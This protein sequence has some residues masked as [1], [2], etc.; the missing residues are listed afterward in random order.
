MN[1]KGRDGTNISP[2]ER[3]EKRLLRE[4]L[5]NDSMVE[6]YQYGDVKGRDHFLSFLF[7]CAPIWVDFIWRNTGSATLCRVL[8]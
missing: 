3:L 6:I 8:P 1:K 5:I 7:L 2:A 4:N